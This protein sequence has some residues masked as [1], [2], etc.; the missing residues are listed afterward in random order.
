[1]TFRELINHVMHRGASLHVYAVISDTHYKGEHLQEVCDK[2]TGVIRELLNLPVG[3]VSNHITKD[4]FIRVKNTTYMDGTEGPDVV[5]YDS[6]EDKEYACDFTEWVDMIDL[7]V[8]DMIGL[9]VD[10]ML[11]HILYEITFWGWNVD[12]I[13]VERDKLVKSVDEESEEITSLSGLI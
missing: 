13:S 1:M 7:Q 2:F 8:E 4:I 9:S 12:Q 5:L 6:A 11:A 10:S 3:P